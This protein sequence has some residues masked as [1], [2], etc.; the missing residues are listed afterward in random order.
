MSAAILFMLAATADVTPPVRAEICHAQI[1]IMIEDV[2]SQT[3]RVA[4]PSWFVRDWWALRLT[5]AQSDA[6]RQAE[7][8][9]LVRAFRS[10]DP[11]GS[12]A[13]RKACVDEAIEAGA[14]PGRK[15]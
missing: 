4:G 7:V 2:M 15:G 13:E 12:D 9:A 14:V 11:E 1:M 6:S 3:G 10:A 5:D 8:R